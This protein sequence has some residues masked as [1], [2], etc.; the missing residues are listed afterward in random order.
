MKLISINDVCEMLGVSRVTLHQLTK[1][2]P[3]FPKKRYIGTRKV[4]F[5]KSEVEEFIQEKS[6]KRPE[7]RSTY[8]AA[9]AN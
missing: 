6:K 7:N 8:S 4:G 9:T 5:L 1:T 2:D 3:S